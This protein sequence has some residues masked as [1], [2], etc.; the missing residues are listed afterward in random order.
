MF[1]NANNKDI[2]VVK[3]PMMDRFETTMQYSIKIKDYSS[4]S[5]DSKKDMLF[6]ILMT[7]IPELK[8]K[9]RTDLGNIIKQFKKA[10]PDR[11]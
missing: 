2:I 7:N 5:R 1:T 3:G 4:I 10:V 9:F 11:A 8:T 6:Y